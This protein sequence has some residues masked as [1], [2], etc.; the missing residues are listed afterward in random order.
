MNRPSRWS[1]RL[2]TLAFVVTVTPACSRV[3]KNPCTQADLDRPTSTTMPTPVEV[4]ET[5]QLN[6]RE[7]LDAFPPDVKPVPAEQA[8]TRLLRSNRPSSGGGHDE[9]LL[10]V[11]SAKDSQ[12]S[13][14]H[15][16]VIFTSRRAEP[17]PPLPST[18][19]VK[20]LADVAPCVFVDVVTVVDARTGEVIYGSKNTSS[21]P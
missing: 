13:N 16:W 6:K 14:T 15:A 12:T 7:R 17:I 9:L 2:A 21:A 1:A 18:P 8:W 3:P 5:R 10:G 20:P 11:F 19:G 4:K